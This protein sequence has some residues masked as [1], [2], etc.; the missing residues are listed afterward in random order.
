MIE[1][2]GED[3]PLEE[4]VIWEVADGRFRMRSTGC[5]AAGGGESVAAVLVLELAITT[6]GIGA[7][8]FLFKS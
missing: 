5:I 3:V 7:R 6:W 8:L 4:G 2:P 1:D